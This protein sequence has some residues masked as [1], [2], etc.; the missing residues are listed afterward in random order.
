MI[1]FVRF[2]D[3]VTFQPPASKRWAAS[4]ASPL[5]VV[6]LRTTRGTSFTAPAELVVDVVDFR[7]P[8][9]REDADFVRLSLATLEALC[10]DAAAVTCPRGS[11]RATTA[12]TS[13]RTPRQKT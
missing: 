1:S 8:D 4:E 3:S 13:T 5:M 9:G 12:T 11:R 10:E 2:P 7:G 6:L